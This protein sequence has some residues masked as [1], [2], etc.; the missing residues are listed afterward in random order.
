M[1]KR[2]NID[3]YQSLFWL[4]NLTKISFGLFL[5]LFISTTLSAQS[6]NPNYEVQGIPTP[7]LKTRIEKSLKHVKDSTDLLTWQKA[8][9]LK[10]QSEGRLEFTLDSMVNNR[11]F[12][13][14]SPVYLYED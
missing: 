8:W 14:P 7:E 9:N 6:Q 1:N 10:M 12:F 5:S 3:I 2:K 11:L 4:N 13:H